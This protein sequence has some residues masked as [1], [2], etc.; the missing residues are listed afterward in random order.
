MKEK[1][2]FRTT[3]TTML[4]AMVVALSIACQESLED[5]CAREAKEFNAKKCPA[6]V[7]EGVVLD[8]LIFER[9]TH[10][11]HYYYTF[12]GKADDAK[13]IEQ[14]NPR[15]ILIDEVKNSTTVKTYKDAKYKFH[16]TY[17]S[18]SKKTKLADV[19][20]TEKDYK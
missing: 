18:A 20:I 14:L 3:A 19:L 11:L 13:I 2:L 9:D 17:T 6:K 10:T 15:K 7:S 4:M 8:S 1:K 5:R 12:S 16:Y